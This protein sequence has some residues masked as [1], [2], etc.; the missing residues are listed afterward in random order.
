[1]EASPPNFYLKSKRIFLPNQDEDLVSFPYSLTSRYYSPNDKSKKAIS[2]KHNTAISHFTLNHA[3]NEN[4]KPLIPK[5]F[6]Q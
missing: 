4:R 2:Y 5:G 1:M 6:P 3:S